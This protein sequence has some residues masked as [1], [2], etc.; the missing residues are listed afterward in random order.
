[1]GALSFNDL[2]QTGLN[3]AGRTDLSSLATVWLNSWLRSQ[4]KSWPWPF[5]Y[6][7]VTNISLPAGTQL[8][9]VGAGNATITLP[10]QQ[11][12]DPIWVYAS[13]YSKRSRARIR[14]LIDGPIYWDESVNNPATGVG[15]PNHFKVRANATTW[16]AWDLVPH[17]IPDVSY[18]LALDYLEQ[19]ADFVQASTSS[20][21][22]PNDHTMYQAV[23]VAAQQYLNNYNQYAKELDVLSAMAINDRVKYGMV[24]GTN[25]DLPLDGEIFGSGSGYGIL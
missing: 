15:L 12:R 2:I 3:I 21:I 24:E 11:V 19:P 6:R 13:D 7:R 10:I 23:V 17:P 4:Y 14:K 20:P 16:G 8:L 5:L 25:S 18:L 22:Y 9:T 1:M